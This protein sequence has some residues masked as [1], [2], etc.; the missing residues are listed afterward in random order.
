M[1]KL[2]DICCDIF[3]ENNVEKGII[4]IIGGYLED[5]ESL[6]KEMIE[7]LIYRSE[8]LFYYDPWHPDYK[9]EVLVFKKLKQ[10]LKENFDYTNEDVEYVEHNLKFEMD[11][12][13]EYS[14]EDLK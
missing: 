10:S 14:E 5:I 3:G 11:I 9:Y 8:N 4:D 2:F 1:D 12:D 6:K 7:E 13:Y